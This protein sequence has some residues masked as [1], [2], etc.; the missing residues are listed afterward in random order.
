MVLKLLAQCVFTSEWD[1]KVHLP[2]ARP[3]SEFRIRRSPWVV[4]R[5][6]AKFGTALTPGDI[7]PDQRCFRF[8]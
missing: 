7:I 6:V 1:A 8:Q 2:D 3:F 5:H 4:G